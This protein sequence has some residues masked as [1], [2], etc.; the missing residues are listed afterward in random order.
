[1]V[2]F[3]LMECLFDSTHVEFSDGI[4]TSLSLIIIPRIGNLLSA[5]NR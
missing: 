1:M 2:S 3:M 4:S 5:H